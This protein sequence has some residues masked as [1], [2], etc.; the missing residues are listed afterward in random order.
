L[1]PPPQRIA[2]KADLDHVVATSEEA[3]ERSACVVRN[4]PLVRIAATLGGAGAR[5][6]S[7]ASRGLSGSGAAADLESAAAFAS[8]PERVVVQN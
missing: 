4:H 2:T 7:P 3:G 8:P 5:A 6:G 1:L